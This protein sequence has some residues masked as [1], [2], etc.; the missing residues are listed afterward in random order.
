MRIKYN[1]DRCGNVHVYKA[2]TRNFTEVNCVLFLQMDS[3]RAGFASS[4]G[5]PQELN[6]SEP[7]G[8]IEACI[9]WLDKNEGKVFEC[10][11]EYWQYHEIDGRVF[12][13]REALDWKGGRL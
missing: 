7:L 6:Y 9:E 13:G 2:G 1:V 11:D 12:Y 3:D 10:P 8:W 4:L 5:G